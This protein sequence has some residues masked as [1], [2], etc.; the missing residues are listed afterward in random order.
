MTSSKPK[1][2]QSGAPEPTVLF[3]ARRLF[4]GSVGGMERFSSDVLAELSSRLP[5]R[6][7]SCQGARRIPLGYL[8]SLPGRLRRAS[9]DV[10]GPVVADGSDAT[11]CYAL[12]RSGAPSLMR[13]H[14]LD[15]LLPNPLYQSYLRRYLPRVDAFAANSRA[16]AHLLTRFGIGPERVR[17]VHPA[18][19]APDH[20]VLPAPAE[21]RVLLLGRLVPRKGAA[22]FVRNVWPRLAVAR[23]DLRLDIVGTGPDEVA[24]HEA[25]G[26]APSSASIAVLGRVSQEQLEAAWARAS[27]LAMPNLVVADDW[28][29]FGIV[30][31]EAA[32]RG[33]PTVAAGLQGI[34][35][36][37]ADGETGTLVPP[38]DEQAFTDAILHVLES[39]KF[40]DRVVIRR[41]GVHRWGRSRLGVEYEAMIRDVAA[42]RLGPN[43]GSPR[44]PSPR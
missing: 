9:R 3:T 39:A 29:G 33:V 24:I 31:A 12:Q 40:S 13:V 26:A 2:L 35:D 34:P 1:T 20:A 21:P 32:V 6:D 16:T 19:Q 28:E 15:L 8:A 37:V 17:V 7:M 42:G 18:A 25:A 43:A 10:G 23:P 22:W 5:V 41:Q 36:A 44:P 30:A 38:G 27:L 14:G 4:G 11:L